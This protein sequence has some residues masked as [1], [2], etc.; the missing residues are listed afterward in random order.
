M[1]GGRGVKDNHP[2][3]SSE[4]SQHP[5]RHLWEFGAS[6]L[7][8]LPFLS[9]PLLFLPS[10]LPL[11]MCSEFKWGVWLMRWVGENLTEEVHVEGERSGL[12]LD[13]KRFS[14]F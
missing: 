2:P 14:L 8:S 6:L 7:F 4:A 13:K 1:G 9:L 5:G 3:P 11:S 12:Q 10:F